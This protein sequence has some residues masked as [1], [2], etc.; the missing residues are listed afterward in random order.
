MW[1]ENKRGQHHHR[2]SQ[3]RPSLTSTLMD[4]LAKQPGKGRRE[5]R[6]DGRRTC[7]PL[8]S[9]TH[10]Y[11]GRRW[12]DLT[13]PDFHADGSAGQ[14]A[15]SP[16]EAV[17]SGGRSPED[18]VAAAVASSKSP[19]G[20]NPAVAHPSRN[21]PVCVRSPSLAGTHVVV[22][23]GSRSNQRT[24]GCWRR[25]PAL[26]PSASAAAAYKS[27]KCAFSF[28]KFELSLVSLI[29]VYNFAIV[30]REKPERQG[31]NKW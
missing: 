29:P 20:T 30:I 3:I 2:T 18:R 15:A 8:S 17:A 12:Q 11:G 19:R 27:H 25:G 28:E 22:G 24:S 1:E 16:V 13:S 4:P 14:V 7:N 10:Q 9:S 23:F 31:S 26:R 21:I 6:K 5:E